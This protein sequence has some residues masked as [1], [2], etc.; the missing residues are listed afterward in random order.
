MSTNHLARLEGERPIYKPNKKAPGALVGR[1][2][3]ADDENAD[4]YGELWEVHDEVKALRAQMMAQAV[5]TKDFMAK[6]KLIAI[7]DRAANVQLRSLHFLGKMRGA[8]KLQAI[9]QPYAR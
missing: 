3:D 4:L 2:K 7:A 8:I 5:A 6:A 1:A 9:L